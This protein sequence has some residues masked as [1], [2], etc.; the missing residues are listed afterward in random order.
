[1][2]NQETFVEVRDALTTLL[3]IQDRADTL[4][5][6]TPLFGGI[7]ELDSMAVLELISELEVRF[8]IEVEEDEVTGEVF[9]T[10]GTLTGYVERK[11]RERDSSVA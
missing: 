7:P 3:G 9:D 4:E 6:D 8:G 11:R 1:M 5:P 2:T 10:L